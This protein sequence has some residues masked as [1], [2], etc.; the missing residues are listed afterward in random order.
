[1]TYRAGIGP[2]LAKAFGYEPGPPHVRC[3]EPGC[4]A[5]YEA[6]ETRFGPPRWLLDN[7]APPRW[8]MRRER[9]KR[10]DLC[11]VHKRRS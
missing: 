2:G 8:S 3:D 6:K 1:M 10:I 5:T 11:P 4:D 9:D 7:K